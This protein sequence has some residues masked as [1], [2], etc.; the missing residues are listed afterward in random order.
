MNTE[1]T[2]QLKPDFS[3]RHYSL[4]GGETP[5]AFN[6]ALSIEE[7][8][9]EAV[10]L[11]DVLSSQFVDDYPKNTDHENYYSLKAAIHTI[12]DMKALAYAYARA[13]KELG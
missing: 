10:A 1:E 4:K 11:L 13:V 9:T 8:A 7:M 5:T 12:N 3:H 6:L 2:P